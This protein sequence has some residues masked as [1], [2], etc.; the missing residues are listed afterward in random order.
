MESRTHAEVESSFRPIERMLDAMLKEART[1]LQR[2]GVAVR[3]G[4]NR[5]GF[6]HGYSYFV[7]AFN[8]EKREDYGSE[9]K[10]ATARLWYFEPALKGESQRIEVTSVAEIFQI[11]KPSRV[12]ETTEMDFPIEQ[13][14]TMKMDQVVLDCIAAARQTLAKY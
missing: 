14:F 2:K 11:G 1:L 12:R 5:S 4:S 8:F 7:W 6:G 3:D 13:F 10:R 9:I